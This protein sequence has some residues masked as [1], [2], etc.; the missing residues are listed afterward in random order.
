MNGEVVKPLDSLRIRGNDKETWF[1]RLEEARQCDG[2]V[3]ALITWWYTDNDL[4]ANLRMP[5]IDREASPMWFMSPLDTQILYQI[6]EVSR[7]YDG[8]LSKLW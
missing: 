6:A 2:Q 8:R 1:A 5:E 7:Y 3:W 4:P